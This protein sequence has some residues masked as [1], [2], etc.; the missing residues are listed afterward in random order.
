[1]RRISTKRQLLALIDEGEH[2]QQDFKYRLSDA[3]K[4]AKSI[5][6]FANTDGGRLLIGVRD[7]RVVSGVRSEEEIFMVHDAAERF[8]KPLPDI[9]Y[10]TLVV[11]GKT[12]VVATIGRAAR[13]PVYAISEAGKP[14]AYVRVADENIV[15][16]AVHLEIWRQEALTRGTI[17]R[18][19][20]D[21]A[22]LMEVMS[23][24]P[25][26]RIGD[27]VRLSKLSRRKVV[28]RLARFVRFGLAE[29][30]YDGHDFRF[31]LV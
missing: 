20:D 12:V 9:D 5:S 7:D 31:A 17:T 1:M 26:A 10:E 13:R 25:D 2:Q 21:E 19:A 4:I 23:T 24:M 18:Y 3:C 22:R 14:I 6:A 27:I 28:G 11:E 15:A 30:T 8:C 16:T 29:M